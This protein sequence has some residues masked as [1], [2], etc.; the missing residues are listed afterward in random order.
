MRI[1]IH[2]DTFDRVSPCGYAIFEVDKE[3]RHWV[4]SSQCGLSLP[5]EGPL[6]PAPNGTLVC[7]STDQAHL[8]LLE[9]LDV[10]STN[11]PFEGETGAAM[12]YAYLG[13]QPAA[14]HWHVELIEEGEASTLR[15]R[16]ANESH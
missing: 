15:S 1:T 10:F 8:C 9:G 11:G 2:I 16:A 6:V 3:A 13:I 7:G 5:D 4:C 14:G 12:W